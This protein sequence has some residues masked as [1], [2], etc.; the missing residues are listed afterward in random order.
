[1]HLR[2]SFP[3]AGNKNSQN[4]SNTRNLPVQK[5][6]ITNAKRVLM[7]N[8]HLKEKALEEDDNSDNGNDGDDMSILDEGEEDVEGSDRGK[9]A[10][11]KE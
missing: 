4:S 1:M 10:K 9:Q 8:G 3:N 7:L 6:T 11:N 2:K 5:Q